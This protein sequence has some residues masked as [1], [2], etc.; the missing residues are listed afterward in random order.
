ML[1]PDALQ[2]LSQL[3]SSL[4][5]NRQLAQGVVRTTTKRFGFV[6]LDDGREAF[7][8]P[9]QM[10]RVLPTTGLRLRW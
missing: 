1:N 9:D 5:S 10:L 8:D 6:R 2:Q 3:K 7:I 4:H